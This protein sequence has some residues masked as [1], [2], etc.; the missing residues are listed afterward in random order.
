MCLQSFSRN[1]QRKIGRYE[2]LITDMT[3]GLSN[4]LS[5]KRIDGLLLRNFEAPIPIL[6]F[7]F[8]PPRSEAMEQ[9]LWH[10]IRRLA[11]LAPRFV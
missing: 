6:S 1:F 8:V 9:R 7:E 3:D 2:N 4:W 11:P 10:C 5:G